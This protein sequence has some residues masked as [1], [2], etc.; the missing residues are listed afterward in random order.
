MNT[1]DIA[2]ICKALGDSNRMQIVQMYLM[3]RSVVAI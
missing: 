2:V 1:I 3:E